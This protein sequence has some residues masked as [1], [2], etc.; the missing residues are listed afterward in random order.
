MDGE[1]VNGMSELEF[2]NLRAP[3]EVKKINNPPARMIR[4]KVK[5]RNQVIDALFHPKYPTVKTLKTL[6]AAGEQTG[7]ITTQELKQRYPRYFI[8]RPIN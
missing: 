8:H 1:P 5:V 2:E 6:A 7:A 3:V 4:R